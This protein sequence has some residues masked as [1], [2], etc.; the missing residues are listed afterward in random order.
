VALVQRVRFAQSYVFKY[1]PRPGTV[2]ADTLVDDV[3]EAEK[4]RR[5]QVL[6]AAQE[7]LCAAQNRALLG[8]VQEVLVEGDSKV[9]GR[10]SGRTVHHRLVHFPARD[11]GLVGT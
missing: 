11:Q 7:E 8:S 6:L 2:A 5:N 1:S 9:D 3:P 10:M 4:E